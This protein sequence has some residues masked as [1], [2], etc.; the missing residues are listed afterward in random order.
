MVGMNKDGNPTTLKK[1]I[2]NKKNLE[3]FKATNILG[4]GITILIINIIFV[5]TIWVISSFVQAEFQSINPFDWSSIARILYLIG[6]II[7]N[8]IATIVY[9]TD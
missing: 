3:I 8:L 6:W 5:I 9:W 7:V 2:E 1:Y 4:Y